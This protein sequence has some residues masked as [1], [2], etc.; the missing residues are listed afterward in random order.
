[1]KLANPALKAMTRGQSFKTDDT[2]ISAIAAN[3]AKVQH[4]LDRA[5]FQ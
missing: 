3:Q 5:G 1:M 4:L 2:S